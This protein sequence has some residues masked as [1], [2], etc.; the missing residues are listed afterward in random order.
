MILDFGFC[1]FR[2]ATDWHDAA[3]GARKELGNPMGKSRW[4]RLEA[5]LIPEKT[6]KEA[7]EVVFMTLRTTVRQPFFREGCLAAT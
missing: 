3:G 5:G 1:L 2:S 7:E 4:E 6:A